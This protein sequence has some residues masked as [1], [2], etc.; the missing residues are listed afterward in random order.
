MPDLVA[1]KSWS[2]PSPSI[3]HP[4]PLAHIQH[5]DTVKASNTVRTWR[6]KQQTFAWRQTQKPFAPLPHRLQKQWRQQQ[7]SHCSRL[8]CPTAFLFASL[9]RRSSSKRSPPEA[10]SATVAR[11]AWWD[12]RR[13]TWGDRSWEGGSGR[14]LRGVRKCSEV[15]EHK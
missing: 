12:L 15:D 9:C 3:T 5:H 8:L 6:Q 11:R 1:R 10:S 4:S 2:H 13:C 7:H 14:E